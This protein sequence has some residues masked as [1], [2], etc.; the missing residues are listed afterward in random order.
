MS[1]IPKHAF[2]SCQQ[3]FET[4]AII[5]LTWQAIWSLH[6]QPS[7]DLERDIKEQNQEHA[8]TKRSSKSSL[9]QRTSGYEIQIIGNYISQ[10]HIGKQKIKN[11]QVSHSKLFFCKLMC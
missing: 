8:L 2:L 5:T 1:S 6:R 9:H 3:G 11:I 4:N 10:N 7:L